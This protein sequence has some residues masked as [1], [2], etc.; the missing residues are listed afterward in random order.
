MR[1]SQLGAA[2][3]T[4]GSLTSAFLLPPTIS[5]AESDLVEALP[6]VDAVAA[7]EN[8][9]VLVACPGC[10]VDIVDI[11]GHVNAVTT[12]VNNALR[13]NISIAPGDDFDRLILNGIQLYP[14]APQD[15]GSVLS[16]DQLVQ[17]SENLWQYVGS[18]ELGYFLSVHP[19]PIS[20]GGFGLGAVK[21]HME[22]LQVG[23]KEV[24]IPTLDI[25]LVETASH[26]IMIGNAIISPVQATS[27]KECTSFICRWKAIIA[28]KLSKAKGC[29]AKPKHSDPRPNTDAQMVRPP[30]QDDMDAAN[31]AMHGHHGRPGRRPHH[32][33]PHRHG[34]GHRRHGGFARFIRSLVFHV[35]I[36]ILIGIAMG[37]T[38]S[39]V[40][41]IVGHLAIFIWRT[42]FR[43]SQRT[44]YQKV[45]QEEASLS[46]DDSA[47]LLENQSPPPVY[48]EA[49]AY[50]E[51]VVDEKQ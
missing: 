33:R 2:A 42:L 27:G 12:R 47:S 32:G 39:L 38:A 19:Q 29:G 25:N 45:Q 9:Q 43:R 44:E 40:G 51:A 15:I 3:V 46:K 18:P 5:K 49:P 23:G 20:E 1:F 28:D 24:S 41:M 26:K 35:F 34:H 11:Q 7:T 50:E 4:A 48:E 10:P 31:K 37:I 22:V 8:R 6:L 16:A 13:F 30:T 14:V 21:I 36:P 17:T